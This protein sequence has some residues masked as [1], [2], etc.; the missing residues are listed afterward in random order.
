MTSPYLNRPLVPLAVA[1]PRMLAQ[2][3]AEIANKELEA[4]EERRLR[5]RAELIR[6]LL[7]PKLITYRAET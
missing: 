1:L 6:W 7:A 4:A 2:I 3:E 5:R